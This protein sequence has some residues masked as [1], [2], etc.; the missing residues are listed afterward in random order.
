VYWSFETPADQWQKTDMG[1]RIAFLGHVALHF[2]DQT[3][4]KRMFHLVH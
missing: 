1:D 2:F 4:W 3:R